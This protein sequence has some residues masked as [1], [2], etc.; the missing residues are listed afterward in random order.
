VNGANGQPGQPGA[1]GSALAWA[2]VPPNGFTGSAGN[3]H[4]V[5]SVTLSPTNTDAYRV[6][7]ISGSP[8]MATGSASDAPGTTG[9][10]VLTATGAARGC[11]TGTQFTIRVVDLNGDPV[12]D[13]PFYIAFY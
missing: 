13:T 7:G 10:I 4:N 5:G 8:T 12:I 3:V 2:T 11:P 6:N 9:Y 1:P